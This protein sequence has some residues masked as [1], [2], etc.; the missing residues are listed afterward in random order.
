MAEWIEL[1][2][3]DAEIGSQ[4]GRQAGDL[5]RQ[6][7]AVY[8]EFLGSAPEDVMPLIQ[9]KA[10]QFESEIRHLTPHLA[11]Q[12]DAIAD[13]ADVNREWL[14]I[15]N[16]RSE[17]FSSLVPECTAIYSPESAY[18]A[19]NWDY[20]P[21]LQDLTVLLRI[22]LE[23]GRK[24]ITLTEAGMV[25]K[26]GLN[27][28]GIGVCL[29]MLIARSDDVGLPIHLLLRW[30]LE[31]GN[32]AE[33]EE[34]I[35]AAGTKR[36]G[37]I[38]I[39]TPDGS[40]INLEYS[41]AGLRRDDLTD[42]NFAHTNHE[43]V[44]ETGD[45]EFVQNSLTRLAQAN[46]IANSHASLDADTIDYMLSNRSNPEH[47]IHVPHRTMNGMTFGTLYSVIMDLKKRE[48]RVRKGQDPAAAYQSFSL[49][50]PL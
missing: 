27:D 12:I 34:R 4:Y 28:A 10:A 33:L 44:V 31:A 14:Y 3:S 24:L 38:L 50:E 9:S 36:I 46:E 6:S 39:G 30:L 32:K 18:L 2:G 41:N 7:I 40:G 11:T 43:L 23:N 19:Q 1:G 42:R 48:I 17:I 49:Q 16:A 37:N 20:M 13:A 45:A 25:G 35:D 29:N 21:E 8:Q 15:V 26:I 5:I 22:E 47:P